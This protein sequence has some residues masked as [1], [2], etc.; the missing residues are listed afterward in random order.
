MGL[1]LAVVA[2]VVLVILV[3]P[4]QLLVR[5][6]GDCQPEWAV[7]INCLAGLVRLVRQP[8]AIFFAV[9]GW[10]RDIYPK[11]VQGEAKLT[12]PARVRTI[13]DKVRTTVKF[14]ERRP[15]LHLMEG[16]L[17]VIKIRV[18]GE[19]RYGLEDPAIA[20][21]V[22]GL[23]CVFQAVK[24]LKELKI[25]PDFEAYGWWGCVE[26]VSSVRLMDIIKPI[27]GYCKFRLVKIVFDRG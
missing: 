11:T 7:E 15:I 9:G 21:W 14:E 24:P 26:V 12:A 20:A 17:T 22:Y 18:K 1:V 27:S 2:V 16:I 23:I 5:I 10:K 8:D 4:V 13:L 6:T 25:T 3:V 19:V